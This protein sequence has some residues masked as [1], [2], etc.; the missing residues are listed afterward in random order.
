MPCAT[1]R[2]ACTSLT[3]CSTV[4]SS[5]HCPCQVHDQL[6]AGGLPTNLVTGQERRQV[7]GARHTACTTEMASTSHPI[8]VAVS[9][10]RRA[11]CGC[12]C[13]VLEVDLL[14]S[15]LCTMLAA[16]RSATPAPPLPTTSPRC[17]TRF[18]CWVMRA[19]A[20]PF[21]G[22]CWGCQLAPC[23]CA[24]TLQHC[25]CW[26]ASWQRRVSHTR[27]LWGDCVWGVLPRCVDGDALLAW[28]AVKHRRP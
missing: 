6:C 14:L 23:M 17:W 9:W 16:C 3:L 5:P 8:D 7:A 1:P 18:R 19:V 20:G 22:H 13:D 25:R 10:L 28:L 24:A 4:S 26:S 15:K 27:V 12:G 11:A 2:T 21:H